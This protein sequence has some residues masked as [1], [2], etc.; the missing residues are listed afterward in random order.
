MSIPKCPK[1][2]TTAVGGNKCPSCGTPIKV[3]GSISLK[4]VVYICLGIALFVV[5]AYTANDTKKETGKKLPIREKEVPAVEVS[6]DS[7]MRNS[8]THYNQNIKFQGKAIQVRDQDDNDYIILIAT[9]RDPS[10]GY[11]KSFILVRYEGQQRFLDGDILYVTGRSTGLITYKNPLKME[12][13]VPGVYADT[14]Q[15]LEKADN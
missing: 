10:F 14:I 6:Y 8:K 15:L 1:C 3:P 11:Y 2:G 13:T 9:K 4:T 7:L 5:V 12:L